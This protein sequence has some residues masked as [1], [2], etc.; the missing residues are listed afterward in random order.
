M[1]NSTPMSLLYK[2]DH[3]VIVTPLVLRFTATPKQC[4]FLE[5]RPRPEG[6]YKLGSVRPVLSAVF[7]GL[8]HQFFSEK[9]KKKNSVQPGH[10]WPE[11]GGSS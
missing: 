9:K 6:S 8:A 3:K 10:I 11:N 1:T 5:P 7:S 2:Y 4:F